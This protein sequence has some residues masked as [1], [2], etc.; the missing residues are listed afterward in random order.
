MASLPP[1]SPPISSQIFEDGFF[2]DKDLA[3]AGSFKL[4]VINEQPA[5]AAAAADYESVVCNLDYR[6]R[7]EVRDSEY[8]VLRS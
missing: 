5:A 4:E 6:G 1:S 8:G 3:A 2:P 7:V